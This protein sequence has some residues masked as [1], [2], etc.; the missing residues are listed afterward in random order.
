MDCYV[1]DTCLYNFFILWHKADREEEI[2]V[3][4]DTKPIKP[5]KPKKKP[6]PVEKKED[7]EDHE[8]DDYDLEPLPEFNF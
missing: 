1:K 5:R 2:I 3:E 4:Q 8:T 7:D 6:K